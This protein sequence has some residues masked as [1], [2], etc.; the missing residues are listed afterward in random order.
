MKQN[1]FRDFAFSQ[2]RKKRKMNQKKA[3]EILELDEDVTSCS[4]DVIKKK[5][6]RMALRYHPDKNGNSAESV[7]KFQEIN[8]AYD[9]LN[10]LRRE[11]TREKKEEDEKES[12]FVYA[13]I[14]QHF[15]KTFVEGGY[16]E[17]L[18]NLILNFRD[19]VSLSTLDDVDKETCMN[20]YSF[21]SKH[22]NLFH[23]TDEFIN[24]V[25]AKVVQ[26]YEKTTIYILNPSLEDLINT[27]VYRMKIEPD[28]TIYVPLWHHE[29]HFSDDVVVIC[30]PKLPSNVSIDESNQLHVSLKKTLKEMVLDS[31][32]DW[33]Y[34]FMLGTKEIKIP[35]SNLY[36]REK[37]RYVIKG[38]GLT[39]VNENDIYDVY[40]RDDIVIDICLDME[41]NFKYL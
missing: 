19:S 9:F 38:E 23:L 35:L 39:R 41:K 4:F 6:H 7:K 17:I 28:R 31:D 34:V 29:S 26:K 20:I 22:R 13:T 24:K 5:Y 1:E 16:Q 12:Q 3:I 14:L 32:K 2:K 11:E 33:N 15:L 25:R 21:L 40:K 37:Q 36:L 18:K 27:N 8:E 30:E 10:M